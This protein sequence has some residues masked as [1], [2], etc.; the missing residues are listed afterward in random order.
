[1]IIKED[2]SIKIKDMIFVI[3]FFLVSPLISL[4]SSLEEDYDGD[5]INDRVQ[6]ETVD[7]T[8]HLKMWLSSIDKEKS[9]IIKPADEDKIPTVHQSYKKGYLE[10]DSTYYSVQGQIYIELYKWSLEKKTGF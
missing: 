3:T 4:G 10:L 7:N 8:L 9:Y 2:K 5:G 1:M 6:E